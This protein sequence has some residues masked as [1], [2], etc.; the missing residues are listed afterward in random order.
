[1]PLSPP[2]S[3]FYNTHEEA[4]NSTGAPDYGQQRSR[5]RSIRRARGR[6][7][8]RGLS[9]TRVPGEG[10]PQEQ[11]QRHP[12]GQ[13][14]EQPHG[15]PQEQS[16]TDPRTTGQRQSSRTFEGLYDARLQQIEDALRQSREDNASFTRAITSLL[17]ARL[18]SN[19]VIGLATEASNSQVTSNPT[20]SG[21]SHSISATTV[22]ITS[23]PE[24]ERGGQKR[25][26]TIGSDDEPNEGTSTQRPRI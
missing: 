19:S 11:P 24:R 6:G 2:P 13:P 16:G 9:S 1:M 18:I 20:F 5:G 10:H 17:T 8:R 22:N 21:G 15:Q 12:Q 3:E 7:L 23:S 25:K 4:Y 26:R 14:Q